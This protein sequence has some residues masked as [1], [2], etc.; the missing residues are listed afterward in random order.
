MNGFPFPS[1]KTKGQKEIEEGEKGIQ[2]SITLVQENSL[3]NGKKKEVE[4]Q[5]ITQN[6]LARKTINFKEVLVNTL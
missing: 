1:Y 4:A 6:F 3:H 2:K 5:L